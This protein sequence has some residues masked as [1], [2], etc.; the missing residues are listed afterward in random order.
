VNR[1]KHDWC[2]LASNKMGLLIRELIEGVNR[3]KRDRVIS[4]RDFDARMD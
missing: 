1:D 2:I 4:H 3:T